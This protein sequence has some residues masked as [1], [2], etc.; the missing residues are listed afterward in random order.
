M[1]FAADVRRTLE[2]QEYEPHYAFGRG[3]ITLGATSFAER[4]I[5]IA[6]LIAMARAAAGWQRLKTAQQILYCVKAGV[7]RD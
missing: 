2:T 7:H 5:L 3:V 1:C 6:A 4:Y